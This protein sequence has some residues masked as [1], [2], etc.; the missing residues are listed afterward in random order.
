MFRL[1]STNLVD[2]CIGW[3]LQFKINLCQTAIKF[4][5]RLILVLR[6]KKFQ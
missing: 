4:I 3:E 1:K 6:C 2:K 5:E